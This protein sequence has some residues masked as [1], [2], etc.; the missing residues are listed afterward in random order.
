MKI[1]PFV[2]Y[3]TWHKD[4]LVGERGQFYSYLMAGNG[5]FVEAEGPL[6]AARVPVAYAP[7]RGLA[8]TAPK[9][10]LR[11]GLIPGYL[12]DMALDLLL[13]NHH[14]ELYV[15]ILWTTETEDGRA[16][17]TLSVP[18]Q[19]R[20]RASVRYERH[21]DTILDLHSHCGMP[22]FFSATDD[23][24]EVGFQLYGVVGRLPNEPKVALRVGVY[25]YW[26]EIA[27]DWVF[28]GVLTG[29]SRDI[30]EGVF[31]DPHSWREG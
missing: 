6:L 30:D 23:K 11:H 2:G 17:Y 18:V 9:L 8:P 24:D 13:A 19:E 20:G 28:S 4:G 21:P 29:A 15:A 31:E 22:A 3:L 7:V 10:A 12:W 14:R 27:W 25:G 1:P 16:A 26:Q 5:L